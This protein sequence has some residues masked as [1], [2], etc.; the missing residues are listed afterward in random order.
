MLPKHLAWL[1]W[2]SFI[3][4]ALGEAFLGRKARKQ[5]APVSPRRTRALM[6]MGIAGVLVLAVRAVAAIT[7]SGRNVD[8]AAAAAFAEFLRS[9]GE[10]LF[11]RPWV[12]R[13][14]VSVY[15]I[16]S[17]DDPFTRVDIVTSAVVA[18]TGVL[19]GLTALSLGC[20]WWGGAAAVV[21][22]ALGILCFEG[23]SSNKEPYA[24]LFIAAYLLV[25]LRPTEMT[26]NRAFLSGL[27]LGGAVVAKDQT[28]VL[29]LVE[30]IVVIWQLIRGEGPRLSR[31]LAHIGLI[32]MGAAILPSFILGGFALHGQLGGLITVTR[33]WAVSAG[34]PFGSLRA[35]DPMDGRIA[36]I[37]VGTWF[38][39]YLAYW[40]TPVTLA[41]VAELI[42][43][44]VDH[45]RGKGAGLPLVAIGALSLAMISIGQ[46]WFGHYYMLAVPVLTLLFVLWV[47]EL[48]SA[49]GT[50]GRRVFALA[51]GVFMLWGLTAAVRDMRH[52]AVWRSRMDGIL[53]SPAEQG[54]F[55]HA[56][57][58]LRER[59][60]GGQ[61]ILVWGWQPQ[62]YVAARRSPVTRM[63]DPSLGTVRDVLE[64]LSRY[65]PPAAVVLPGPQHFGVPS[66]AEVV[67][68]L[69]RH[70]E[71]ARWL[72]EHHY[73]PA[74][75]PAQ[76]GRYVILLRPDLAS[77]E[78][79]KAAG[80][81][82]LPIGLRGVTKGLVLSLLR[83][84][85][86]CRWHG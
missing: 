60:P 57:A 29:A 17:L 86:A 8:E 36:H 49:L 65:G 40:R 10:G 42:A 38:R 83:G 79:I 12:F 2:T 26:L 56:T 53:L 80:P 20:R 11:S 23:L 35:F 16:G 76:A 4:V 63:V 77:A 5:G 58:F 69:S 66:Q 30:P 15:L 84:D 55:E 18:L 19:I 21:A 1:F 73:V 70:P 24:N 41:G 50:P 6:A 47:S 31:G 43:L 54:P 27:C 32:V 28:L 22:Y 34:S 39:A 62:L 85:A 61:R 33:D 14:F 44:T 67:Y 7:R 37:S 46:R 72:T 13:S 68:A 3:A 45:R 74:L 52:P 59:I 9:T 71:I 48:P 82:S 81:R 51:L 75:L 64:D 78:E 25:R